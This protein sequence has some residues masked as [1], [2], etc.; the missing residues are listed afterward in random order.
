MRIAKCINGP[1]QQLIGTLASKTIGPGWEGD[2]DEVIGIRSDGRKETVADQLRDL[3]PENFD[4]ESP[5]RKRAAAAARPQ[6]EE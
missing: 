5:A 6:T 3:T 2:L 1:T 4:I